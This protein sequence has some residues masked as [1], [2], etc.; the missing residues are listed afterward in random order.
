MM[1]SPFVA[2]FLLGVIISVAAQTT[3]RVDD[4]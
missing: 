3:L 1:R 2:G 4:L